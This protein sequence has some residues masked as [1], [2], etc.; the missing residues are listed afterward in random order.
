MKPTVP[1][2]DTASVVVIPPCWT[3][4][5]EQQLWLPQWEDVLSHKMP[6][7]SSLCRQERHHR[8]VGKLVLLCC[9]DWGSSRTQPWPQCWA[10][11]PTSVHRMT[12]PLALYSEPWNIFTLVMDSMDLPSIGLTTLQKGGREEGE[13]WFSTR[14]ELDRALCR[15]EWPWNHRAVPGRGHM[16][17]AGAGRTFLKVFNKALQQSWGPVRFCQSNEAFHTGRVSA[18]L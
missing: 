15:R 8:L 4:W 16:H 14:P 12:F 5:C 7:C 3:L 10:D 2:C 17:N 9:G 13:L 6:P 18:H 11:R 1:V